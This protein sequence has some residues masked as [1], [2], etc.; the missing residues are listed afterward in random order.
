MTRRFTARGTTIRLRTEPGVHPPDGYAPR[1][2]A[3]IPISRG[4]RVLDLGCGCGAFGLWAARAGAA[5]CWL[6]DIDP[7][8]CACARANARLNRI[9]NVRIA[10]GDFFAPCT[11]RR[12]DVIV[13]NV[14]Q[15]P[16]PGPIP[17]AKWG[18]PGGVRH[19][20]R[21]ARE[22]PR[23]L[24]PGGRVYFSLIGLTDAK[25]ALAEF[26]KRFRT[27]VRLRLRRTCTPEEFENLRPGLW[28]WIQRLKSAGRV[29]LS[30]RGGRFW[31]EVRLIEAT[32]RGAGAPARSGGRTPRGR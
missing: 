13:G 9:R 19:L 26:G 8:A 2:A 3:R 15:T 4:D 18:G 28:A 5:E 17:L 23:H 10:A 24:N 32:L 20:L 22:A 25:R 21:L 14:P 29:R 27:S 1:E 30:R 11:G 7:S 16:A 12:F 6:T 31:F